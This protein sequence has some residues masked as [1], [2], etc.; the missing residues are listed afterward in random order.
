M[1]SAPDVSIATFSLG[2]E[3][4]AAQLA[5]AP[6]RAPTITGWFEATAAKYPN[7]IALTFGETNLTYAE[8]NARANVL[9]K[10]LIALGV[11]AESLVGICIDRTAE[12]VIAILAVVKAGGAYVP[13]D[14]ASPKDR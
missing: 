6:S 11:K 12:L 1:V 2:T 14:P 9:A 13:L 5:G 4:V 3:A 10:E 8:L 7:N